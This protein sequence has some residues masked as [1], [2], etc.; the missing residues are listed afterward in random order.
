MRVS[1]SSITLFGDVDEAALVFEEVAHFIIKGEAVL[2]VVH[3]FRGV[4]AQAPPLEGT[5]ETAHFL[6]IFEN[7]GWHCCLFALV[8]F[9]DH[10]EVGRIGVLL[11]A[12]LHVFRDNTDANDQ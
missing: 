1:V 5:G 4:H 10:A 12:R 9:R 3:P 8:I 7:E 11:R 2:V 6:G